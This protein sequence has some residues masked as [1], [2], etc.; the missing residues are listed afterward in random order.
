VDSGSCIVD[1]SSRLVS[2]AQFPVASVTAATRTWRESSGLPKSAHK[3][4]ERERGGYT[5]YMSQLRHNLSGHNLNHHVHQNLKIKT[6]F[7]YFSYRK[8]AEKL[9]RLFRDRPQPPLETAIFWTEYVIRHGGAPHLRSA[10]TDLT[11]YQ[12]LLLDVVAVIVLSVI[13]VLGALYVIFRKI[14]S[15]CTGSRSRKLKSNWER[16]T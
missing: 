6:F 8:N 5:T 2:K 3:R 7:Y 9:S 1:G 14:I 16:K 10:A 15:I 13:I 12:Y 4:K 11:W